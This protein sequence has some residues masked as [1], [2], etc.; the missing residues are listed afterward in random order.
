MGSSA[1]SEAH[2]VIYN[3]NLSG[4][5]EAPPNASPGTG[6]GTIEFDE[7]LVTMKIDI[8]FNGLLGNVTAA[9]IHAATANAF[10]GTAG[11]A[12][13][14]PSFAGFPHGG[15]SGAYIQTFDL[16]NASSYNPA[17]VTASG[18]TVSDALNALLFAAEDGKAYLNIHTSAFPGGEIRGFLTAVPEPSSLLVTGWIAGALMLHRRRFANSVV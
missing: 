18:G 17:F 13:Q 7:D 4:P 8:V 6:T 16:T 3:V 5:A 14:L 2:I 15:T 11:V 10:T 1:T 12:T 9:H